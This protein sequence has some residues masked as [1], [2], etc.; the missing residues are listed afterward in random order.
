MG[1]G[2]LFS[3]YAIFCLYYHPSLAFFLTICCSWFMHCTAKYKMINLIFG[4]L[5]LYGILS[6][7]FLCKDSGFAQKWLSIVLIGFGYGV[8]QTV[9][10]MSLDTMPVCTGC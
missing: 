1:L 3:E 10:S 2:S 8:F 5:P 9:L 4:I 7:V 6:L